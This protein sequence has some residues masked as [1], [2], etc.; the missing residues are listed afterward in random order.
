MTTTPPALQAIR[1]RFPTWAFLYNPFADQWI[2][3]RGRGTTL[4]AFTAEELADHVIYAQSRPTTRPQPR[5]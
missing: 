5:R 2:A 3:L 4:A 1:E